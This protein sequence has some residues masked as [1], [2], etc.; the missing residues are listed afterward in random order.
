MGQAGVA[1]SPCSMPVTQVLLNHL[2]FRK[3][4][5]PGRA[6]ETWKRQ[7]SLPFL[8][9]SSAAGGE[10][11]APVQSRWARQ[12]SANQPSDADSITSPATEQTWP[13]LISSCR[14]PECSSQQ[15]AHP[16]WG[17][18]AH[19]RWA[20]ALA[21]GRRTQPWQWPVEVQTDSGSLPAHHDSGSQLTPPCTAS[22]IHSCSHMLGSPPLSAVSPESHPKSCTCSALPSKNAESP[23][24]PLWAPEPHLGL[25][26]AQ[27]G[28]PF[29]ACVQ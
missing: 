15:T 29:D 26:H 7:V 13:D 2:P 12:Q 10:V 16:E 27:S 5:R 3:L 18:S 17:D 1:R 9:P 8:M 24:E 20:R 6:H 11:S 28:P 21:L 14:S 23:G 25:K 19:R 4:W 22:T